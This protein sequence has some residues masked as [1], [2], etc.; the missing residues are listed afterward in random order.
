VKKF[1]LTII[2]SILLFS[3]QTVHQG[4]LFDV[5]ISYLANR[6]YKKIAKA[7]EN[8]KLFRG[9]KQNNLILVREALEDGANPNVTDGFSQSALMWACWNKSEAIVRELVGHNT[10]KGLKRSRKKLNI[11]AVSRDDFGYSALLCAARAGDLNIFKFLLNNGGKTIS[12][13]YGETVLHK[14]AKSGNYELVDYII[15]SIRDININEN[16]IFGYTPLFFAVMEGDEDIT[17]LLL[18]KGADPKKYINISNN[19]I[20]SL[21]I[22][23]EKR[24]YS[25]FVELLNNLNLPDL[26]NLLKSNDKLNELNNVE[27]EVIH[28]DQYSENYRYLFS[29]NAKR[30]GERNLY[31]PKFMEDRDEFYAVIKDEN[32][33]IEYIKKIGNKV[34]YE[35]N[36]IGK[37][38]SPEDICLLQAINNQRPDVVDYLL[39]KR[40]QSD[41]NYDVLCYSF[42]KARET[43]NYIIFDKLVD[44]FL[45]GY[46]YRNVLRAHGKDLVTGQN[47]LMM[48]M[49]DSNYLLKKGEAYINRIVERYSGEGDIS[50]SDRN[51]N[52]IIYHVVNIEI[53]NDNELIRIK[54]NIFRNILRSF[55]YIDTIGNKRPIIY[56]FEK[57]F[58]Y[59]A[60]Y[61]L[62]KYPE[63]VRRH[64]ASDLINEKIITD[65]YTANE[66]LENINEQYIFL[67]RTI[68]NCITEL[69]EEEKAKQL[70][71]K[72]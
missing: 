8:L 43:N 32:S 54:E 42:K 38:K 16:S 69:Q 72:K 22:A 48:I 15:S 34:I 39:D 70:P 27:W 29:I 64:A 63:E 28:E 9:V 21:S 3:C 56:T 6:N 62:E 66:Y 10:K 68:E 26:D 65:L 44:Y 17:K 33:D 41:P 35:I 13:K 14:A 19:S 18:A 45:Q 4:S 57:E 1:I 23:F 40:F 46:L 71:F 7:D 2:M 53:N 58:Y 5:H 61:L 30:N 52:S 50:I 24:Y 60:D 20:S 37:S 47:M 25:V 11:N 55:N 36:K 31:E 12:D 51:N 59:G 67:R 49:S